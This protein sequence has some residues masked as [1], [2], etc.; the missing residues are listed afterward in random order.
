MTMPD[1]RPGLNGVLDPLLPEHLDRIALGVVGGLGLSF[2]QLDA[3]I[4]ALSD[5]LRAAG[6]EPGDTIAI[7]MPNSLEF[8]IA[9]LAITRVRATAAPLNPAYKEGE[10]AF[11]LEDQHAVVVMDL[12]AERGN[13]EALA[14]SAALGLPVWDVVADGEGSVSLYATAPL[15]PAVATTPVEPESDV[16]LFLHTSGSTSRP[17]G[18]PLTH[19]NLLASI[20]NIGRTYAFDRNDR[21]LLVMPLFHVHGLMAG[22]LA[23]LAFGASVHL[24][25]SGR[26]SASTFWRDVVASGAT[27]YTAVPTIHQILLTRRAEDY[28]RDDPPKL[29]FIRSCSSPLAPALL[30]EMEASFGAPVLE[31]YAMTEAAH[32]VA[33][34]PLP[35]HGPHKP[36]SVGRAQGVDIAILDETGTPCPAA[37]V[38][39]VCIRGSNVTCGYLNNPEANQASFAGGWFH[40]GDQGYLD[41][42]GYLFI[43][44]RIK[45]IINRGGEK[46]SPSRIDEVLLAHPG[47][48]QAVSFAM[49]DP[50]YGEEVAA[51]IIP[52]SG[53]TL[54][55]DEL[56]EFCLRHLS[57]FQVPKRFYFADSLPMT[58][59]GK[60]Q[61]RTV[62]EHFLA[63]GQH[64]AASV[65]RASD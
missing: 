12:P 61:R 28:P 18:V 50:K 64:A 32:Q 59:S 39:E 29:R 30:S 7:V 3:A 46:I 8:V 54:T 1:V 2:G 10:F 20:G 4:D 42:D 5:E 34:N 33:S 40:T 56:T 41:P 53:V 25:Q 6:V 23:P 37:A 51:A 48:A 52:K 17:K 58:G 9:F 36:G 19:A 44:G 22:L 47:I 31:A 11:F 13:A 38:G 63:S 16:A 15:G 26:F 60:I 27:W 49:P 35:Q 55:A 65:A 24:P 21:S 57:E 14:A 45:E 43:T 62:A